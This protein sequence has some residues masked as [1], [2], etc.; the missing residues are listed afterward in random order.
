MKTAF[1]LRTLAVLRYLDHEAATAFGKLQALVLDYAAVPQYSTGPDDVLAKCGLSYTTMLML[2]DAGLVNA[3]SKSRSN[4]KGKNDTVL[5]FNGQKRA[6]WVGHPNR[7][8]LSISLNVHLLTPAGQQLSKIAEIEANLDVFNHLLSW[9]HPSLA[10][11]I[12]RTATLPSGN[13]SGDTD[14]L[15]W[16]LLDT[17]KSAE[18]FKVVT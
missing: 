5:V 15:Q 11:L 14:D 3:S 13:C 4:V 6:I 8:K 18:F 12:V 1:S 10:G 2:A 17:S 9:M 7:E 16:S